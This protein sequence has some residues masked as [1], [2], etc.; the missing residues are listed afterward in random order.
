MRI[1]SI[2]CTKP[3]LF[4]GSETKTENAKPQAA[5]D[6]KVASKGAPQVQIQQPLKKD[7]VQLSGDKA[8]QPQAEAPKAPECKECCE[9]KK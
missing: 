8:Q 3:T 5:N 6:A 2:F 9:C 1:N 7:T 4:R